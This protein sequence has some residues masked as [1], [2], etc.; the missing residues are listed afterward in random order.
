MPVSKKYVIL[1]ITLIFA[2]LI[3]TPSVFATTEITNP[4]SVTLDM[5]TF[6]GG[7]G[8]DTAGGA[9]LD[10]EGNII[11]V[12]TSNSDDV[13]ATESTIQSVNSGG[14]DCLIYKL[15]PNGN[16]I[17]ATY[18]GGSQDEGARAIG[19]DSGDNI[20]VA[21]FT[22]SVDFPITSG[23]SKEEFGGGSVDG[24]GFVAKL[25]SDGETIL[26]A[27]Y[28]GGDG[29]DKSYSIDIAMLELNFF[30]GNTS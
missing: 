7:S 9:V 13:Q 26:W 17:F 23:A 5:S 29:S 18:L 1:L 30:H 16:I 28:F 27:T 11:I 12:T 6:L 15:S 10:S 4:N 22:K 8:S 3:S 20:V 19:V 24:D 21:G 2:L 14:Y 25:S